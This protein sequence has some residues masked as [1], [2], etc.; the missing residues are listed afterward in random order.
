MNF[1]NLIK[2]A[3]GVQ[4]WTVSVALALA[5][6]MF[7]GEILAQNNYDVSLRQRR[8][9]DQ[10]GVEIWLKKANSA[11]PRVGGISVAVNYNTS[12]LSPADPT[13]YSKHLTDSIATDIDQTAPL[14][15]TTITSS[16]HSV[17]GYGA[18]NTQASNSG[19]VFV[20]QLEVTSTSNPNN[21]GVNVSSEGRGTF[22]GILRFDII[23]EATLGNS[24]LTN[25]IL[26]TSNI[27][28]VLAVTDVN[29]NNITSNT[30]LLANSTLTIKGITILTP[31]S[32]NIAVN[33][34]KTYA[35]LSTAGYP[36]YFE[37]SGLITPAI[38][39]EYGSNVL[40]YGFD[41]STN[42]GTTWSAEFMRVAEHRETQ[43]DLTLATTLDNHRSGSIV[44]STG[45]AAGY[46]ITQGNGSQLPVYS[47]TAGFG[48]VLRVIWDDD[49]NFAERSERAR[50]RI[51]QL[52][53]TPI[54]V[55]TASIGNRLIP[56]NSPFDINDFDFVLSRLFFLQLDGANSYLKTRDIYE[57]ATQLTVEAWINLNTI[58]PGSEP[59]LVA[60]G[61]GAATSNGETTGE[62]AWI[63]YLKDGKFPAFRARE[64]IGGIGRGENGGIY[65]AQVE[66]REALTA[67]SAAVPIELNAAHPD[68]WVH[69]AATVSGGTVSLYVNGELKDRKVNNN[70]NNIR[71]AYM[72][73]PVWIGVNPT[74]GIGAGDYLHAG[75]KEVKVWKKALTQEELR[76]YTIGVA[77]PFTVPANDNRRALEL[78]YPLVGTPDDFATDLTHQNGVNPAGYYVLPDI[79]APQSQIP[80]ERYPYR[81]DRAHIKI[82]SPLTG[83]GVSNLEDKV[84][85]IRWASYGMGDYNSN[86]GLN[87]SSDLVVEF[88]RDGGISWA[89]AVGELT[90]GLG[91]VTPA[92]LLNQVDV[93]D[94]GLGWIPYQNSTLAGAYNDLQAV[95]PTTSNYSKSVRL[96]ITGS[97]AKNQGGISNTTGIF[98]VAPHF[99]VK[100]TGNSV[101]E[102]ENGSTMNLL[103]GAAM[104]EAWVRPYRF[105]TTAED[106]FPIINKKD[107]TTGLTHYA[108]R[109]LSTGQ[110]QFVM[111]DEDGTVRTANSDITK[112]VVAPN[113]QNLDS[114]W[115]HV[116]VFMNL[117]NGSGA[118]SIK[119]YIDGT[120]QS[121]DSIMTQLGSNVNPNENNTLPVYLA[122]EKNTTDL[123]SKFFIGELRGLRYWNGIPGNVSITGNEPSALT[124]FVRGAALVRSNQLSSTSR[125][126]LTASFDMDGGSFFANNFEFKSLFSG[127]SSGTPVIDSLNAEIVSNNGLSFVAAEPYIKLVE[128]L[129]QQ[130]VS[131]T[132][133][134]LMVRWTGFDFDRVDFNT[135]DNTISKNSDLEYS[136]FGGGGTSSATYNP[137]SSDNDNVAFVDA[138]TLPLS[139]TYM[140]QGVSMAPNI[141]FAG[142]LD[143]SKSATNGTTQ[144]RLS[145]VKTDA[146]LRM[147]ARAT[148][149]TLGTNEYTTFKSLRNQGP[150]F[151][152]TPASNFT[153][154]A[155]LEGYHNGDALSFNGQVGNTF[156]TN[157][158]R[159]TLYRDANGVPGTLVATA[160]SSSDYA[161]KDPLDPL[162]GPRGVDGSVFGNINFVFTDVADGNY[163]VVLEQQNHL[164]VMSRFAAPFTF[165]GDNLSTWS[166]ES[167]WDFQNWSGDSTNVLLSTDL[168][169]GGIGTKFSAFGNSQTNAA[170]TNYGTTGLRFNDGQSGSTA[171]N[172]L[173]GLI[174]G[175]V[176]RDG[177]I[178]TLDRVKVR[179]NNG[180]ANAFSSDVTGE[181]VVNA[182]DRTIVDRNAGISYSLASLY[183]GLYGPTSIASGDI[184]E[185]DKDAQDMFNR[186]SESS[187]N[188]TE[189]VNSKL[190]ITQSNGAFDY[191]VSAETNLDKET[192][193]V[194]LTMFIENNGKAFAPANCTFA[195]NYDPNVLQYVNLTDMLA[196]WNDNKSAGY[197]G[198]MFS[199]PLENSTNPIPNLRTI[200]IDYDAFARLE[201]VNVPTGRVKIGTLN[202]AVRKESFEYAFKWHSSTAVL[203]TKNENVTTDGKFV[204]IVPINTV[205]TASITSPNG[206]EDFKAGKSYPVTWNKPNQL[207]TV[208]V[209][210]SIDNGNTWTKANETA[211]NV[212]LGTYD[213]T[214]PIINSNEALVR[215][216]D[217]V[218][219]VE[220]DRTDNT[221]TITPAANF[222]TRPS[223]KDPIY[224]GGNMDVIKFNVEFT[225]NVRFAFSANGS[226]NWVPLTST[227][228]SVNGQ[229]TWQVPTNTNTKN[230]VVAMYDAETNQFLAVSEP[231]KVLAGKVT[232]TAPTN[233]ETLEGG[234]VAKVRWTSESVLNFDLE[235]SANKG[236]SW[237]SVE[238]NINALKG[239]QN[240]T[241]NNV[242]TNE[243]IL[244]AIWNNDADLEFAR[245]SQFSIVAGGNTG[246]E[247]N[248]LSFNLGN[249]YPNP[250]NSTSSFEFTLPSAEKVYVELYN[251]AG[252]KVADLTNGTM[253]E[254]GQHTLVLYG[255]D[256]PAGVYFIHLTAGSNNAVQQVVLKK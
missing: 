225:T 196:V 170:L 137:T 63:L 5:L 38:S 90:T 26:N 193:M 207:A 113:L 19:G 112:P 212:M 8:M 171:S 61:P 228:N 151:S 86:T 245:T 100:N 247:E 32:S 45:S 43:S 110:I 13:T 138:F 36:I 240:W 102:I 68:N 89:P 226:N 213:W 254:N 140:F 120:L 95:I 16:F 126:N 216:T 88:S 104:L 165:T 46:L 58:T 49:P 60:T 131:N 161:S 188:M 177:R 76:S 108:L 239:L 234:K 109:L 241:V 181:G 209:E 25:I 221:F 30:T 191:V 203:T 200:E 7:A 11:A 249:T 116:S 180:V 10:I 81:P 160:L 232:F 176:V 173:A 233:G 210:F 242:N 54:S 174:G 211:I 107:T 114:A 125:A 92:S 222:I 28:G 40:A 41:Y 220:I 148:V 141:Q 250:F 73:H 182:I 122:W 64:A 24:D 168:L 65:I 42:G 124:N 94:I 145:A 132:T 230:A 252:T 162:N 70:A 34:N 218:T 169:P 158:V 18:L 251:A 129:F 146:R 74:N 143:V 204:E 197:T 185:G 98:T 22:L 103:G 99:A 159:I 51:T 190:A 206:G 167:G 101:I 39:N 153:V 119:F 56:S 135:G 84:F 69:I 139:T 82:T 47:S 62:G 115:T 29:G 253:L 149:N 198:K 205:K 77:N 53:Q 91:A 50:I 184:F 48:G 227:V 154:R 3:R 147:R 231:F 117:S 164:P 217:A 238:R 236:T 229:V 96:R 59:A 20:N 67:T 75:I 134:D 208:F 118:S 142:L 172:Q 33:R 2:L 133:T 72:K 202:F 123:T 52:A 248:N 66:D 9:G 186:L 35:S 201:G 144:S 187:Q 87:N 215:L 223:A 6:F 80:T 166:I 23:N 195:I 194:T 246:V 44:S 83:A 199:A 31:N 150:L 136:V 183:P 4:G 71:M 15:F 57:N 156:A 255:N 17:N 152:I 243:G 85:P 93:E 178:N 163:F 155:L 224:F 37:R 192:N 106:Y 237:T 12:F 105:P 79:T 27:V 127:T 256:L 121:A 157:G 21:V 235:F 1:K 179:L 14:P 244:R 130:E 189:E 175:D 97:A 219:A 111:T 55:K 78:Y 128:P 214:T